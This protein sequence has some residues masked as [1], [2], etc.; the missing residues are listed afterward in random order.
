[1][2]PSGSSPTR[3]FIAVR[4]FKTAGGKTGTLREIQ[5]ADDAPRNHPADGEINFAKLLFIPRSN[6]NPKRSLLF[7]KTLFK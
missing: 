1:M 4:K 6:S 3:I 5:T 7:W 2:I